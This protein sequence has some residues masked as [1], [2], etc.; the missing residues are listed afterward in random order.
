MSAHRS[1]K[2]DTTAQRFLS[3]LTY[4]TTLAPMLHSAPDHVV[5]LLLGVAGRL[6]LRGSA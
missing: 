5:A 6:G 1:L 3:R 4:A 2:N